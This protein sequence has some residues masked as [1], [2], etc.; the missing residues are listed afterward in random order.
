MDHPPVILSFIGLQVF[1]WGTQLRR[2]SLWKTSKIA[3]RGIRL[4][5]RSD[6]HDFL[7]DSI[8]S[9]NVDWARSCW[10]RETDSTVQIYEVSWY[11]LIHLRL[12]FPNRHS[13]WTS[14]G[15]SLSDDRRRFSLHQRNVRISFP[16]AMV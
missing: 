16:Q 12:Y 6:G 7:D 11:H 15:L 3:D 5:P 13:F 2:V 1:Q 10:L 8:V 14:P 4:P 9:P